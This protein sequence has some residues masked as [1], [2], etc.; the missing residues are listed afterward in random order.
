MLGTGL[1][2]LVALS[3]LILVHELGHFLSARKFQ[4][5]VEEFGFGYPP[6]LRGTKKGETTYSLNWIPFGGFVRLLGENEAVDDPRSFSAQKWWVRGIIALAGIFN[7]FVLAVVIYS[8]LFLFT[9]IPRQT[10]VVTVEGVQPNSPAAEAGIEPGDTIL[11]VDGHAFT[12]ADMFVEYVLEKQGQELSLRLERNGEERVVPII[13]RTEADPEEGSLGVV[14]SAYELYRPPFL[15]APFVALYH[16]ASHTWRMTVLISNS[17]LDL[18]R[19]L[20]FRGQIP[21]DVAGPIGI[22]QITSQVTR[23]GLIAVLEFMAMLSIN[24]ALI[25]FLPIP[26]LDGGRFIFILL[27]IFFKSTSMKKAEQLANQVGFLLIV[28]LMFAVTFNDLKRILL[29]TATGLR[30][31]SFWPF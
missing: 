28:G 19:N 17:L 11:D 21:Q 27:S 31:R 20:L 22:L 16:G 9:G 6:R 25:N 2:F 5:K 15:Q 29:T 13:G 18:F 1:V 30:I 26:G 24:L 8:A 14:V 10:D 4:V 3:V 7:N 23:F 12:D